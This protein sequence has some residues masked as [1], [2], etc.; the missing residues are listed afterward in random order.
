MLGVALGLAAGVAAEGAR[1]LRVSDTLY[2]ILAFIVSV[3]CLLWG[4]SLARKKGYSPWVGLALAILGP[5]GIAI[6]YVMPISQ[7]TQPVA[8]E[9]VRSS[10]SVTKPARPAGPDDEATLQVK[11]AVSTLCKCGYRTDIFDY[12]PYDQ[13]LEEI[14]ALGQKAVPI[15]L[16]HLGKSKYVAYT[17]GKI[18]TEDALN[19]L[20]KELHAPD[21]RRAEAA[22]QGLG[23]SGTPS[24]IPILE[25]ARG[26]GYDVQ[27]AEV[28]YA[29][30]RAL[31]RLEES[32]AGQAGPS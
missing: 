7:T 6:I 1:S 4:W 26:S 23:A 13:A 15:L 20:G 14:A 9:S 16:K 32:R 17:L 2:V 31:R 11:R 5:I 8:D 19:A 24:A 10:A 25:A 21:W 29:L 18:A 22:A 30:N 28:H 3:T 12:E 27:I